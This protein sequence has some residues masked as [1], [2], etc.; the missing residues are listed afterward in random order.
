MIAD[1]AL[2]ILFRSAR[3]QNG[4]LDAPVSDAELH[5]VYDLLKWGPASV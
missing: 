2:D 4:W 3:S 1:D 5:Q